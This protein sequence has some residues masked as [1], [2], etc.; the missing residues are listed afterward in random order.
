M[1]YSDGLLCPPE[2]VPQFIPMEAQPE[3]QKTQL[4]INLDLVVEGRPVHIEAKI[5]GEGDAAKR[6]ADALSN[7]VAKLIERSTGSVSPATEPAQSQQLETV[8]SPAT[9][10]IRTQPAAAA[11]SPAMV[12]VQ[13]NRA[14]I[15]IGFGAV[16]V[17]LALLIPLI[18][19]PAQRSD[20]LVL[21]I[22]FTLAGALLLF[23]AFLPGRSNTVPANIEQAHPATS[24]ASVPATVPAD[25]LAARRGLLLRPAAKHSAMKTGLGITVGL[26]FIVAGL[27]APFTLGATNADERFLIMLGFIPISV[28]GFFMLAVY[29]RQYFGKLVPAASPATAASAAGAPA[30]KRAPVSRVP[31]NIEYR[32][33]VPVA[34]IS[35]LVLMIVVVIVVIFATIASMAR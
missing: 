3:A 14:R 29:G 18:V 11:P 10:P 21:T 32:A 33:I 4:E 30:A 28:V 6:A 23:T 16:L 12:W 19:P 15:N 8:I 26:V 34:I 5:A 25:V 17:G 27:V 35:S 2:R 13:Q 7:A 20:V 1:N 24:Q 9:Q 31:Q 22:L